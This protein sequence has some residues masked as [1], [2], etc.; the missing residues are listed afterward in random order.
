MSNDTQ[1]KP[2]FYKQIIT[3]IS[4]TSEYLIRWNLTLPFGLGTIKLHKICRTD[5]DRCQHNHPWAFIRIILWGGYEEVFGEDNRHQVLRPG[6][7]SYCPVNFR[8]RITR[9]LDGP[10]WSLVITGPR[11]QSWGF[12][13]REGF[14]PWKKF[15]DALR[16]ARIAWCEDVSSVEPEVA[17]G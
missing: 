15:V 14:T 3:D 7:I 5:N 10:S 9:L 4:R 17:R 1:R 8:H 12:F 16:E 11:V 6:T 2:P 13:T